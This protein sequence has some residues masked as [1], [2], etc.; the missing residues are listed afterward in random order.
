MNKIE[1]IHDINKKPFFSILD[2]WY[3]NNLK[4]I[5][6]MKMAFTI[7]KISSIWICRLTNVNSIK[8]E[9]IDKPAI[10]NIPAKNAMSVKLCFENSKRK[11]S[12]IKKPRKMTTSQTTR[13]FKYS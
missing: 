9:I 6:K 13:L 5:K 12:I 1:Y 11:E 8:N 10:K 3:V 7:N 2:F 4:P